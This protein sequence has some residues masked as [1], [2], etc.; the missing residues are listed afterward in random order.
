MVGVV[1]L[2]VVA[3]VAG[4]VVWRVQAAPPAFDNLAPGTIL[5]RA[6]A[7]AHRTGSATVLVQVTQASQTETLASLTN[8]TEGFQVITAGNESAQVALVDGTAYIRGNEAALTNYFGFPSSDASQFAQRWV[9]IRSSDSG[10]DDVTGGVTLD[11]VLRALDPTGALQTG[12]PTSVGGIS[13]V[14]VTGTSKTSNAT[15]FVETTGA[16]L[17]VRA[18]VTS[19]SGSSRDTVVIQF[20]HWG[21]PLDIKAPGNAIPIS[22]FF[23]STS[24]STTPTPTP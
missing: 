6:Q 2:I 11:S 19:G 23:S 13:V 5:A 4:I 24:P 20:T 15:V 7:A 9:S 14:G 22:S 12:P 1:A 3:V 18:V 21:K 16:H 10:Y 17:P 8:R